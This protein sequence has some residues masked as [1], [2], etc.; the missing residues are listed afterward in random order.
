MQLPLPCGGP[1]RSPPHLHVTHRFADAF[2]LVAAATLSSDFAVTPKGKR[3]AWLQKQNWLLIDR[4]TNTGE[5][6][7]QWMRHQGLSVEPVMELDSF[8]LIINLVALGM[9]L[10]FVPIRALALY[11]R[12][13]N[14]V[15]LPLANRFVRELVVI[16]R[17]ERNPPAHVSSFV[18][19]ILF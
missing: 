15:R 8:D 6:L 12:K 17:H 5:M 2:V 13:R 18:Q 7:N 9:G 11:G 16:V 3:R 19:N 14:L 1:K 10:S 4:Q